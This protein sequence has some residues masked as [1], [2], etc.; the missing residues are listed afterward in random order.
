MLS[1]ILVFIILFCGCRTIKEP[2]DKKTKFIFINDTRE[3]L[4]I[5]GFKAKMEVKRLFVEKTNSIVFEMVN[6]KT[7]AAESDVFNFADSSVIVFESGK[8][9]AFT[10]SHL[11]LFLKCPL[12]PNH[13]TYNKINN[14]YLETTY[15]ITNEFLD[16]AK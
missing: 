13:Y 7:F 6:P 15:K 4:H 10:I 1:R 8:K 12:V 16:S 3:D 14:D 9:I 2:S 11:A 5:Y